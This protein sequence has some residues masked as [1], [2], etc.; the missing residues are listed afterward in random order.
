[1]KFRSGQRLEDKRMYEQLELFPN[2]NADPRDPVHITWNPW[3]GCTKVSPG[4]QHCYVYRR[5]QEFGKDTRIVQKTKAFGLPVQKY[6]AGEFKG[7]YKIPSGS[8]IFTCFSSDFFH[9]DADEWRQDAWNMMR[10]RSDCTF[11]MITK[12]PERIASSLPADWGD[13]YDNVHITCTCEN[14]KMADKRLPLFLSL[15]IRHK[16]IIHEPM[17][18]QINIRPYLERFGSEIEEVSCGGESGPDARVC[19]YAWVLDSHLQCVEHGIS[20]SYHQTGAKLKKGNRIFDIPREKQHEQAHK[21]GLDYDG[22]STTSLLHKE[23]PT[24]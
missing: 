23:I 19:D 7:M 8:L 24:E 2:E 11:Y 6:R 17:L 4:C 1:M 9:K 10:I 18:E 3:H 14:Q 16:G 21:A 22:V 15:P 12:R 20:F 5:D 13:G